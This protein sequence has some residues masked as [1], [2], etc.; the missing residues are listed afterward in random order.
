MIRKDDKTYATIADAAREFGVSPRTI[1]D[2]IERGLI[3]E[4]PR[5]EYGVR[6]MTYFPL[7]VSS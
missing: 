5:L 7:S 3:D 2:W 6:I 1:R 4:P